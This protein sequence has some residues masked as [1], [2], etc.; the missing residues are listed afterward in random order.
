MAA[1]P[2]KRL[3]RTAAAV[4]LIY[5]QALRVAAAAEP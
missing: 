1:P 4:L 2:N 5:L 3:Q